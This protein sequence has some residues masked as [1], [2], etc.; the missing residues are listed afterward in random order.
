MA[1]EGAPLINNLHE[2]RTN[3]T[4]TETNCLIKPFRMLYRVP[5][6]P[7]FARFPACK[8]VLLLV[9]L[10]RLHI[11]SSFNFIVSLTATR[12]SGNNSEDST[13]TAQLFMSCTR[14]L[15]PISG[16]I[17]DMYIPRAKMVS[18]S[19]FISFIGSSI[20]SLFHSIYELDIVYIP[21]YLYYSIHSLAICLLTV[22]SS[23]V[24]ALL[25]PVG[26][27]QLEGASEMRLK[28]YF[29]WHYWCINI[30]AAFAAGRYFIYATNYDDRIT[31]LAS[32]YL[33]TVSVWLALVLLMLSLHL[34]LVQKNKPPGGT[35]LKQVLGVSYCAITTRYCHRE[36]RDYVS[37]RICDYAIEENGGRYSYE[38]VQDVK[39]FYKIVFVLLCMTWYFGVD[40]LYN[41]IFPLQGA[42]IS[43]ALNNFSST[44]VIF[45]TDC[46]TILF[47]IPLIE[48]FRN[49]N[50]RFR[51]GFK[52]ILN[53]IVLGIVFSFG[54]ILVALALN[55]VNYNFNHNLNI[56]AIIPQTM[57]IAI[58]E[59]IAYVGIME[60]VY[61][62][63]PY[64]MIGSVF[65]LLQLIIGV[66][67]YLPTAI[68]YLL[69]IISNCYGN[70]NCGNCYIHWPLCF[71]TKTLDF[72]Y[73]VV[74]AAFTFVYILF[75]VCL[76]F[77]YK[78]RERQRIDV[79]PET[80]N[81]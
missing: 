66:G 72:V 11:Y 24:Y 29:S 74:Y 17:A 65:G 31:L 78:R 58:S 67:S 45:L 22:G 68:Y 21:T 37:R 75:M 40:N 70:H 54:A 15:A 69:Q 41:T 59:C 26:V 13:V 19:F 7:G 47:L 73:Y 38:Q 32:S 25:V 10:H 36:E 76:A 48:L 61:A 49:R 27:D 35:P 6:P 20:Q 14:L 1:R 2:Q 33:A 42:E 51:F 18:I 5:F 34:K 53:K 4:E 80:N 16:I 81:F 9:L 12:I 63:S 55:L 8:I 50:N 57:L 30:G 23:G 43:G 28:S 71:N 79:W 3:Q 56:A 52:K 64:Q 60:F 44:Q 46:M 62:Q 39:T 77:C